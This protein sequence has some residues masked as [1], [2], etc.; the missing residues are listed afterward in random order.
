MNI[1]QEIKKSVS[2][3]Y[4]YDEKQ[5]PVPIGTGFFV[6]VKMHNTDQFHVYFVTAKHVVQDKQKKY[7]SKIFLR[8]NQLNG[9]AGLIPLN[10]LTF[11][12]H[13][14]NDVDLAIFNYLPDQKKYDFRFVQDELIASKDVIEKHKIA[15]GDEVFFAG[16]FTSHIGQKRNQPITRFGKVALMSEEKIEW[17]EP[18]Y[19]AKLMDLYLLECQSFGGNSGSPVFFHLDPLRNLQELN[20]GRSKTFLAG[21]MTGSFLQGSQIQILQTSPNLISLQNL[22]IAAVTPA[23]KLHEILCSQHPIASRDR[24][25]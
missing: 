4:S 6:G 11:I 16:L 8:L 17:R 1:L 19:P 22:G 24:Q 3:I 13:D 25:K 18:E 5:N 14:D 7:L 9:D 2:F 15:E 21:I 23:Y 12:E 10:D 20:D